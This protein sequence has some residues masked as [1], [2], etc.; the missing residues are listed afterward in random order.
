MSM[1]P[2]RQSLPSGIARMQKRLGGQHGPSLLM[3][4]TCNRS[5]NVSELLGVPRVQL[6]AVLTPLP[7]MASQR[8]PHTLVRLCSPS[9]A[10]CLFWPLNHRALWQASKSLYTHCP[11]WCAGRTQSL[12]WWEVN[13]KNKFLCSSRVHV[14][15]DRTR[16]TIWKV[17]QEV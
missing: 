10:T 3:T 4:C 2:R 16:K 14:L 7:F 11:S 13:G 12:V 8:T 1:C 9:T 6:R 15:L 5:P 17:L